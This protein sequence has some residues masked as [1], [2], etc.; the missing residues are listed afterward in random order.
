MTTLQ[1]QPM[2]PMTIAPMQQ[3]GNRDAFKNYV[4]SARVAAAIAQNHV[5]SNRNN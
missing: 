4:E 1:K 5:D 2:L 3:T